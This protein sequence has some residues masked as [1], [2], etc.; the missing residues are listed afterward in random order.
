MIRTNELTSGKDLT[1]KVNYIYFYIF[2][3]AITEMTMYVIV[4]IDIIDVTFIVICL[5]LLIITR[6]FDII[7]HT[8]PSPKN[9]VNGRRYKA[10]SFLPVYG[11]KCP[12][13]EKEWEAPRIYVMQ[14]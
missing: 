5:H 8:R 6:M 12:W 11:G 3:I 13:N 2:N 1:V 10:K 7:S 14:V 9:K 4:V